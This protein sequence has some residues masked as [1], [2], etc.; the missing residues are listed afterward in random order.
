[1]KNVGGRPTVMTPE[2]IQKLEQAFLIG[3]TD[4]EACLVADI[5]MA[6]LYEYCQDNPSFSDRKEYLKDMPKYKARLNVS[7]AINKGDK[8][9]S[10]WY[11]ERKVKDEFSQR[12]E[13]T[14]KDGKD[15]AV[16]INNPEAVEIAKR[17]EDEIK[18]GL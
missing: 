16:V 9:T 14:G 15:L 17:Y 12:T 3:A 11:L 8:N 1:M 5:G 10:Q 7:D 2:T 18:K 6:T 4:R 13:T